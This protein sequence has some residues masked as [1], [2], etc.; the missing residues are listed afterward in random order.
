VIRKRYK[1]I[2]PEHGEEIQTVWVD[3]RKPVR[4]VRGSYGLPATCSR[5]EWDVGKELGHKRRKPVVIELD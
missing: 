5:W 4:R 3:E 1:V 2:C